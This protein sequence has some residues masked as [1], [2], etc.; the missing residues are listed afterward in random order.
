MAEDN[1]KSKRD[2][3]KYS[4]AEAL[5]KWSKYGSTRATGPDSKEHVTHSLHGTCDSF[6]AIW[7]GGAGGAAF[8]A[9]LE[10][11]QRRSRNG[12]KALKKWSKYGSTRTPSPYGFKYELPKYVLSYPQNVES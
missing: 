10:R 2:W 7:T 5:K 6:L 4:K 8:Q 1:Y 11:A 12:P 3:S 9:L